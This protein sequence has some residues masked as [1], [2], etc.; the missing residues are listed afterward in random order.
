VIVKEITA[1]FTV[2]GLSNIIN[3]F[4]ISWLPRRAYK[5]LMQTFGTH[6]FKKVE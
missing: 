3:M 5:P 6:T 2:I 1:G 4:S